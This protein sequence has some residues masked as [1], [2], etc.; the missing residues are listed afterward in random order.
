MRT[1]GFG[2]SKVVGMPLCRYF[3]FAG[4]VLLALLFLADWWMPQLAV[5]PA[6]AD[7]DRTIIRLHS[8]HKWPERIVIDT[9]LPT[10]VPPPATIADAR[11]V[12]VTRSPREAFALMTPAQAAAPAMAPRPAPKR[13]TRTARTGGPVA[14]YEAFGFRNAFPPSW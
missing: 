10:I 13:R 9:S 2:H 11:P 7:V 8:L 4:S 5:T 12:N 1:Q 14:S 6:R 3:V